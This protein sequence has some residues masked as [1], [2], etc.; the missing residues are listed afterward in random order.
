MVVGGVIRSNKVVTSVVFNVMTGYIITVHMSSDQRLSP[1]V[2]CSCFFFVETAKGVIAT[3][4]SH[5][6]YNPGCVVDFS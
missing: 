2:F 4:F 1:S 3:K 6:H 5:V